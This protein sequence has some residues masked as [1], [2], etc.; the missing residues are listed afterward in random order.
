MTPRKTLVKVTQQ[1]TNVVYRIETKKKN[2][3][4]AHKACNAIQVNRPPSLVRCGYGKHTVCPRIPYI[5]TLTFCVL[6]SSQAR[7]SFNDTNKRLFYVLYMPHQYLKSGYRMCQ[8][9]VTPTRH[10]NSQNHT[11][12]T[13]NII[14]N[15][16]RL[17]VLL[18]YRIIPRALC[19]RPM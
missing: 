15:Y 2:F 13:M 5:A 9:E 18:Y 3:I 7:S 19:T 11:Y 17:H 4:S 1:N 8:R 14:I 6:R 10:T 12:L 16:K